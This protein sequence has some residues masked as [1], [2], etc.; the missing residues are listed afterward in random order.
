MAAA[1][2]VAGVLANIPWLYVGTFCAYVAW[3]FARIPIERGRRLRG[4]D[5]TWTRKGGDDGTGS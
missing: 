2:L 5:P 1:A 3:T 4:F